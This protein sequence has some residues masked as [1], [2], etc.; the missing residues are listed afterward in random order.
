[1]KELEYTISIMTRKIKL[2]VTSEIINYIEELDIEENNLSNS[3]NNISNL[4][5]ENF[6]SS[7]SLDRVTLESSDSNDIYD[8]NN[9]EREKVL[10]N[11]SLKFKYESENKKDN[12]SNSD[13]TCP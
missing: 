4:D 3:N 8:L 11:L 1:M 5:N 12:D 13:I 6:I 7:D 2:N 10:D 9:K